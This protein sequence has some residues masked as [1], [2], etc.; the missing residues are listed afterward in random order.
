MAQ[1]GE[2][3]MAAGKRPAISFLALFL[4]LPAIGQA[5]PYSNLYVFGDSLLDSGNAYAITKTADPFSSYP[6]SPPYAQRFRDGPVSSEVLA[7]NLGLTAV[8]SQ[9]GGT[10]Y[11]TGGATS[12]VLNFAALAFGGLSL[13]PPFSGL[14]PQIALLL[15]SSTGGLTQQIGGFTTSPPGDI[16]SS[17]VLIWAG[18]NDFF[19]TYNSGGTSAPA[20]EA[21]AANAAM[22]VEGA[23]DALILAGA[24]SILAVNMPDLGRVPAAAPL[25]AASKAIW[26]DYATT[27]NNDFLDPAYLAGLDPSVKLTEFDI[28]GVLNAVIDNPSSY[29]FANVT[30]A[31]LPTSGPVPI[32]P[33]PCANPSQYVFWDAVHP[34][35]AADKII[36]NL[37][38]SAVPEPSPLALLIVPLL[39]LIARCRRS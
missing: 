13:P 31:C 20:V 27:F 5:A 21:A 23:I 15:T 9:L 17:L 26:T 38:Y 3:T 19:L 8:A 36:G 25:D 35:A 12:G 16:G 14:P 39:L 6:V 10:N 4:L 29:G 33:G 32:P 34:T 37:L 7:S 28:F 24:K 30:D 18:A 22:N 1:R 11:A 2:I